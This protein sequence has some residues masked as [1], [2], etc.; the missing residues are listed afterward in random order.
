MKL[1]VLIILS[2]VVLFSCSN[3]KTS[4]EDT[5]SVEIRDTGNK[6][7][8]AA[9]EKESTESVSLLDG[10]WA[11]NKNENAI[12]YIKDNLL[13][14]TEDQGNPVSVEYNKDYFIIKGSAV[15][16]CTILKLTSDSLW[17]TDE[18]S[19]DTTKLVRIK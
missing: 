17:Y 3:P 13:Y 9:I 18:F 11:E 1:S 12:F 19:D 2:C 10:V 16:K 15:V 6:E 8:Q 14:Y 5:K 4:N 7:V